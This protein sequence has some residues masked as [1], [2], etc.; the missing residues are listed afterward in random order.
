MARS[1]GDLLLFLDDD[2]LLGPSAVETAVQCLA[3]EAPADVSVC[4][5]QQFGDL[6]VLPISPFYLNAIAPPPRW[7]AELA[8]ASTRLRQEIWHHPILTLLKRGAPI[9]AFVV[10][11]SA[12]GRTRFAEDLDCGE[13]SLFW[14]DLAV[15]G[16]R[17]RYNA[18]GRV[19]VRR[20]QGNSPTSTALE[21]RKRTMALVSAIGPDEACLS[22]LK[23]A[24][25]CWSS[26]AI[27]ESRVLVSL[28]RFP[29][30]L[31]KFGCEHLTRSAYR[32]WLRTTV[33][34]NQGE[35]IHTR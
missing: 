22:A 5:G 10:R 28:L 8:G 23:L 24:A 4:C 32:L 25:F 30:R 14:L 12:I 11:R 16:C 35:R 27:Q 33:M 26:G 7:I 3:V 21:A 15:K 13:D 2:D 6:D 34:T 31:L 29:G 17:F 19:Y 20:H 18:A 1:T 9:N